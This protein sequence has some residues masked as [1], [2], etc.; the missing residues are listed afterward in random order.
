MDTPSSPPGGQHAPLSRRRRLRDAIVFVVFGVVFLSLVV[1]LLAYLSTVFSVV[2]T[3]SSGD[4]DGDGGDVRDVHV[5]EHDVQRSLAHRSVAAEMR[6][7]VDEQVVAN[8]HAAQ[9][10]QRASGF[11]GDGRCEPPETA[12]TCMA[13]CPGVTT[14]AMCGEE[15]HSDPGGYA[16]M[17]GAS[18]IKASAAE[19]CDACKAHAEDPKNSERPCNSWVFCHTLPYCWALDTGHVH[20][21]GECWLKHQTDPTNPLYGQRGKFTDEFR[22]TH[23]NAHKTGLMPDGTPRNLSVPT[24]VPWTGGIMGAVVDL[25]I[26]WETGLDGMRSSAGESEVLWRAWETREQNL[27]RGVKPES[28]PRD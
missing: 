13:D 11:C 10:T 21:F 12:E 5:G 4:G 14:H 8:E 17:W 2:M 27:A 18:H 1:S 15:P 3:T 19:C 7:P 26:K 20:A 16:V 23:A 25:S 28:M 6:L 24:H 22:K 9:T